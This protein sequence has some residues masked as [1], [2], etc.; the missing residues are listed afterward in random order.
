MLFPFAL[1]FLS[2]IATPSLFI[3]RFS[4]LQD[5]YDKVKNYRITIGVV[6]LV[7]GLFS[8]L[9]ILLH[10]GLDLLKLVAICCMILLGFLMGFQWIAQNILGSSP[11]AKEKIRIWYFQVSP[12][13]GTIAIVALCLSVYFLIF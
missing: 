6:Y 9:H 1:L 7:Y 13:E 10:E 8:L 12:Y 11:E 5:L 3:Q 2:F 4:K